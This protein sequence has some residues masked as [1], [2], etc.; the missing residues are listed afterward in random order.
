LN[1]SE[2]IKIARDAQRLSNFRAIPGK[3]FC[4]FVSLS[5]GLGFGFMCNQQVLGVFISIASFPI[6]TYVHKRNTGL[7]PFG[8]APFIGQV[9]NFHSNNTFLKTMKVNLAIQLISAVAVLALFVS[10]V[11][12][13]E[14]RDKGFWWAP[15]AS[16]TTMWLAMFILLLSSN[17][18][19][20]TKYSIYNNE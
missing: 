9:D 15:I 8:F 13:L 14:F 10:F 4:F 3:W 2:S 18:Y 7:W 19:F 6:I 11:D 5:V 1:P 12:I 17:N 16:G 20:R